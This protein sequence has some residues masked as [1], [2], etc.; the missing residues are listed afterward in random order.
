MK[1]IA[2]TDLDNSR[3]G[4]GSPG[5]RNPYT[6]PTLV[7]FGRVATL[8]QA[9]SGC[10]KSDNPGCTVVTGNMGAKTSDRRAK[11]C[12]RR[13]GTHP[14]GIDLYLFYYRS[15]YQSRCG[16]GRQFGVMADEVERVMPRA[17]TMHP[18]GYKMVYYDMLG[19]E[20]NI[21]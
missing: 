5:Q 18:D 13:I 6:P 9:S 3:R 17:V 8:T 1:E 21:H 10:D 4:R 12:I 14:L 7:I 15:E 11:E 2:N 20:N 16:Y 19:I